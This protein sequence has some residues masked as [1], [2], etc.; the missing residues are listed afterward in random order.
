MYLRFG[1]CV[2]VEALKSDSL[3]KI[4]IPLNEHHRVTPGSRWRNLPAPIRCVIHNGR[5]QAVIVAVGEYQDPGLLLQRVDAW[6]LRDINL[7]I[8]PCRDHSYCLF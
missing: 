6:S 3:A 4:A 8:L 5:A 1:H 7:C 2:I